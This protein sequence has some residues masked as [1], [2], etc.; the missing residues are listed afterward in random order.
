MAVFGLNIM[1]Q[2][3]NVKPKRM[4]VSEQLKLELIHIN[5]LDHK[6]GDVHNLLRPFMLLII[7][8][9]DIQNKSVSL[10]HHRTISFCHMPYLSSKLL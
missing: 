5:L 1:W 4:G 3:A 9:M 8:R 6:H 7:S 2:Q 10:V